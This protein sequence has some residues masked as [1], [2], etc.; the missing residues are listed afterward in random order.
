MFLGLGGYQIQ[1][2]RTSNPT[3]VNKTIKTTSYV[4]SQPGKGYPLKYYVEMRNDS[5]KYIEVAV[6]R[7][8]PKLLA[9]EMVDCATR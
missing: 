6:V 9:F 8:N 2:A 7:Y 3:M 5:S 1:L 4:R